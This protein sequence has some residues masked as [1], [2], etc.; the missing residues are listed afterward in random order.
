MAQSIRLRHFAS[1]AVA[2]KEDSFATKSQQ[3]FVRFL[4]AE[5]LTIPALIHTMPLRAVP[6]SRF[7]KICFVCHLGFVASN[8]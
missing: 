7:R 3:I 8:G 1:N 2:S 5:L 6:S 4:R